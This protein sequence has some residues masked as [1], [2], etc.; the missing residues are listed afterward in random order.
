MYKYSYQCIFFSDVSEVCQDQPPQD[1]HDAVQP[2]CSDLPKA[3]GGDVLYDDIG[4]VIGA[5]MST[6][7]GQKAILGLSHDQKLFL[8]KSHFAPPHYYTFP[9]VFMNKCQRSFQR[10]WL[11]R[12]TWMVYSPKLN[13]AFCLP[14]ALFACNR[15]NKGVLVN[16]PFTKWT[17]ISDTTS[18]HEKKSYYNEPLSALTDFVSASA[19]PKSTI[20]GL[21]DKE[22]IQRVQNR[23]ILGRIAEA[24]LFCG[25]CTMLTTERVE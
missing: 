19:E 20:P 10:S 9:S 1:V 6:D 15:G 14:C 22:I 8:A 18:G 23:H 16:K 21:V 24:V 12:Y 4:C 25:R 11:S 2:P 3:S 7:E 17:K 5:D 13:G